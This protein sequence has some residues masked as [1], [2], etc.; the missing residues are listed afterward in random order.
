MV[1]DAVL[2]RCAGRLAT[3]QHDPTL[4][5]RIPTETLRI[6]RDWITNSLRLL[7]SGNAGRCPLVPPMTTPMPSLVLLGRSS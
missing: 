3:L 6:W 4:T 1:I 5:T 7:A 2:R